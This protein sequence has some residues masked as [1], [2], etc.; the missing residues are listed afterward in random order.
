MWYVD[1]AWKMRLN[2][3]KISRG[4]APDP[5]TP[6]Q[7][8]GVR[9]GCSRADVW[10]AATAQAAAALVAPEDAAAVQTAVDA[11]AA[12]ETA[13]ERAAMAQQQRRRWHLQMLWRFRP[14]WTLPRLLRRRPRSIRRRLR[15]YGFSVENLPAASGAGGCAT[16]G[17]DGCAG[18]GCGCG[19]NS[20]DVSG[21]SGIG[22]A[23]GCCS[24]PGG[25]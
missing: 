11:S 18:C 8:R 1:F 21:S 13:S 9:Q 10:Q 14:Q 20:S 6:G 16:S 15:P 24:G 23:C 19:G 7:V 5:L 12:A 25:C 2:G 22:G 17:D 4:C 3:K